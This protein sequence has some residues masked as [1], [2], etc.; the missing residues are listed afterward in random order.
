MVCTGV[1]LHVLQ[2]K[3]W[4]LELEHLDV[5]TLPIR[6][7]LGLRHLH[8]SRTPSRHSGHACIDVQQHQYELTRL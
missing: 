1:V 6:M 3:L 7:E 2:T 5:I 4:Q 8:L